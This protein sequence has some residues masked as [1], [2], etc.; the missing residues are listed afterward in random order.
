MR[1]STATAAARS[2]RLGIPYVRTK[3]QPVPRGITASSTPS[4]PASPCTISLTVPSPP[5]A[6]TTDAPS[7]AA[8]AASCPSCPGRSE[9]SASP[10]NP[11][12]SA[13]C[14]SLGQPRPTAPPS[15]AGLTRKTVSLMACCDGLEGHAGHA[16]DG[17]AQVD[18]RDPRELLADHDVADRQ[19]AA[20]VDTAKGTDREQ[21]RRLHLDAEDT[22]LRPALVPARI[23][24]VERIARGDRAHTH[25][26]VELLGGV[27]G[28]VDELPV[29]GGRVRFAADVMACR[30]VGG[31]RRDPHQQGARPQG[32]FPSPPGPPPGG[33]PS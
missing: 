12:A 20:R 22:A 31:G 23:R 21:H 5:T 32:V 30:P 28:G 33:T 27:P 25:R 11:S 29:G 19:Q 4:R 3:S 13:R 8:C 7:S 15:A 10:L 2:S 6:T 26:L 16:V 18:I 24:V 17:R 9:R 1:P 14:A